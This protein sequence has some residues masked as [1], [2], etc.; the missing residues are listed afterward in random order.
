MQNFVQPADADAD[1][2]GVA[3]G[4]EY[5]MGEAGREFTPQ[6]SVANGKIRWPHDPTAVA[7]YSVAT[8]TDLVHWLSATEGVK[9]NGDS[10]EFTLPSGTPQVFVRLEVN[11]GP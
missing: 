9:D 3:N 8:S 6:S 4:I 2:D 5:F 7:S 11:L 1:K 10:V